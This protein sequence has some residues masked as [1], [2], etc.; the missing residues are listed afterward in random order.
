[1]FYICEFKY[2]NNCPTNFNYQHNLQG[3]HF[4][5]PFFVTSNCDLIINATLFKYGHMIALIFMTIPMILPTAFTVERF[6]ALKMAH[7]YEHVRT[8]LG[9]VLVL[10]VVS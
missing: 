9:P 7:S 5:V 1:M 10:V 4:F 6:V 3:Y 2:W 8:L